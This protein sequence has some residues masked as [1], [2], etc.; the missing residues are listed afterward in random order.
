MDFANE[1][2]VI[3]EQLSGFDAYLFDT[4]MGMAIVIGWL[5]ATTCYLLSPHWLPL[6]TKR[7]WRR[8]L[9]KDWSQIKWTKQDFRQVGLQPPKRE[10]SGIRIAVV[11]AVIIITTLITF[12]PTPFQ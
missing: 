3:D 1:T 4:I 2:R 11:M 6:E 8:A 5:W 9:G 10:V 12:R 7:A